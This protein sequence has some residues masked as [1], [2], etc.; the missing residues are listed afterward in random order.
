MCVKLKKPPT[1]GGKQQA[2]MAMMPMPLGGVPP[3]GGRGGGRG[4][5]RGRGGGG[6]RG[7][8]GGR[9]EAAP[10][11]EQWVKRRVGDGV[12][13]QTN[14]SDVWLRGNPDLMMEFGTMPR[15]EA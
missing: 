11:K 9:G 2:L 6:G 13:V 14:K 8:E 3:W 12:Q 10:S 1:A 4:R 7:R 15:S 5:G